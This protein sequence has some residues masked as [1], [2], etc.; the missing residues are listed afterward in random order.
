MSSIRLVA[1][2]IDGT[3]LQHGA[4]QVDRAVFEE[5]RRLKR[6]GI[7]FCAASGRQYKSLRT[8]F[9]PVADDMCFLCENGALAFLRERVLFKT[10]MNRALCRELVQD[11]LAIDGCEVLI[12]G[13]DTSY[14][15]PRGQ[16][17]VDVIV[18]FI[19]NNTK[20]VQ[21]FDDIHEE[22]I[23]V[24]AFRH[25]DL[26]HV[27]DVLDAK[28]SKHFHAAVA[29]L[30]WYDLTLADKGSGLKCLCEVLDVPL[31]DVMAFGDNF[32]DVSMLDIVGHPRLMEGAAEELK[33]R[34][35][36][37]TDTVL[38]VLKTL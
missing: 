8:L 23:K 10:A 11:I 5:I 37:R 14:L 26:P 17:I 35:S 16:E 33:Q 12:S 34:Y 9:E 15:M 29:G 27:V 18:N 24:S 25:D 38:P 3:L 6:K 36:Q 13:E 19:G 2:D 4:T 28:W 7:L 1:S 30:Q 20:I 32:N 31:S 21:S 22:I